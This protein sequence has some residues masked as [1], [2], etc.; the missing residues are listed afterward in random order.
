MCLQKN[1]KQE[2]QKKVHKKRHGITPPSMEGRKE[3]IGGRKKLPQKGE[4]GE[5]LFKKDKQRKTPNSLLNKRR[6]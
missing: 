1:N 2:S 6:T 3:T 5:F 4:K